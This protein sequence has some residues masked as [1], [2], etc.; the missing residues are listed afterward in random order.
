MMEFDEL[1]NIFTESDDDIDY[2][3]YDEYYDDIDSDDIKN[4]NFSIRTYNCLKRAGIITISALKQKTED[5]LLHVKNLGKRSLKEI[6]SKVALRMSDDMTNYVCFPSK[7]G[8]KT[9][10]ENEKK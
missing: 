7:Y 10:K 3:E 1:M 6:K 2:D 9:S 5:E 8:L 4:L